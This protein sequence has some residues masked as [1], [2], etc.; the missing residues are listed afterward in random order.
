MTNSTDLRRQIE[1]Q[2]ML[3]RNVERL[4]DR[5][6][7]RDRGQVYAPFMGL[8]GA[9]GTWFMTGTGGEG[10]VPDVNGRGKSLTVN[11]SAATGV[12]NNIVPYMNFDGINQYLSRA[13]ETPLDITGDLTMG[14]WFWADALEQAFLMGKYTTAGNQRAYMLRLETTGAITAVVCS[15]GTSGGNVAVVGASIGTGSWHFVVM[16]FTPSTELAIWVDDDKQVNTTSIPAS[17]FNSSE[18]FNIGSI[19]VDYLDG[20][21]ALAFLASTAFSDELIEHL[22]QSSLIPF[23]V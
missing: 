3:N 19:F 18:F 14:G 16:R 10:L 4:R 23:K 22:Y 15:D 2:V 5:Q 20:R 12:Y 13:D 6:V 1:A 17:I 9:R 8:P 21:C 7:F 11:N